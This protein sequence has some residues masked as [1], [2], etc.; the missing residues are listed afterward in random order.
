MFSVSS[1][2]DTEL[3]LVDRSKLLN[4]P[5]DVDGMKGGTDWESLKSVEFPLAFDFFLFQT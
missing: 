4:R 2:S 3:V 5:S 1:G